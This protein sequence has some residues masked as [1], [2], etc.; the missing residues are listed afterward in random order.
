[1][2]HQA[3]AASVIN[4]GF[5]VITEP[6]TLTLHRVLPGPIERA[7]DYLTVSGLRRQWLAEGEMPLQVGAAFEMVWH[8]DELTTPPGQRPDGFSAEHRMASVITACE[9]PH[10][11]AFTWGNTGGVTFEL[12]EE[13][14]HVL[15]TLTH[16]RIEDPELQL[17]ISAGWHGHLDVL[18][19]R[20]SGVEPA[21]FW[22]TWLR[23]KS[24]YTARRAG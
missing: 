1:M 7:W 8:N 12:R 24:E 9:P 6:A 11:I 10:K 17:K 16:R 4:S 5:G 20:V 14:E 13:G 3:I 22:E 21:P 18:I 23:L 19:A 2:T 15:L